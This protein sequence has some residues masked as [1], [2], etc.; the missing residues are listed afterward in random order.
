M[1]TRLEIPIP[2][3]AHFKFIERP[4]GLYE[5]E[6]ETTEDHIAAF[7]DATIELDDHYWAQAAVAASLSKKYGNGEYGKGEM[8]KL[9]EAAELSSNYLYRMARTYRTFTENFPRERNLYFKHH[10]I[11]CGYANPVEALA[12]AVEGGMSCGRLEEWVSEQNRKK[13]SRTTRQRK[14]QVSTDFLSHLEHVESVIEEDFIANCPSHDFSSRVYKEWLSQIKFELRQLLRGANQDKIR[15]AIED[16]GAQTCRQI[17]ELTG[18]ALCDVEAGVGIM[19]AQNEYEW[20]NR[21]GKKDD[22][23]GSPEQ[24]L[25]RVGEPDGTAFTES[26]SVNQYTH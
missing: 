22:Q 21:G 25:H 16:E 5:L 18:L 12:V 19:V 4:D 1:A 3:Q 8:E 17:K 24:I 26:R 10:V 20:I 23:R 11:A 6:A 9:A 7:R 15:A 2:Q 14:R 13:A